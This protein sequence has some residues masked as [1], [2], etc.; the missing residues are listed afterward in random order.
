MWKLTCG[1]A[2]RAV[3]NWDSASARWSNSVA[4]PAWTHR[5]IWAEANQL[6]LSAKGSSIQQAAEASFLMPYF[7]A[8]RTSFSQTAFARNQPRIDQDLLGSGNTLFGIQDTTPGYGLFSIGAETRVTRQFTKRWSGSAGIEFSRNQFSDVD[9]ELIGTGV[10]D[11]NTLFIQFAELKWDTS[12]SLLNPTRGSV[13]VGN[14]T[15]RTPRSSL[16]TSFLKL[17]LEARHYYPIAREDS[18]WPHAWPW[19]ISNPTAGATRCP[20]TCAF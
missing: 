1:N 19:G 8:R 14:S 13:F 2:N 3:L 5:N 11:D 15:T 16:M 17:L 12:D 9:P 6:N 18:S 10:A 4:K 7:L 20:G